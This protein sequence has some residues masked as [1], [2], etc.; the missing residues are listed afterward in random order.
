MQRALDGLDAYTLQVLA[1][2]M[3]GDAGPD[4]HDPAFGDALAD[5]RAL[6]LVWDDGARPRTVP[7]VEDLLRARPPAPAAATRPPLAS[8]ARPP[9][10]LDRAGGTG[11]LEAL[12]LVAALATSW[13]AR[14][15]AQLRSGGVGVRDLHRT[16]REL[17][18][19]E[20]TVALLAETAY[21]AGLLNA[22]HEYEPA[23][24]PTPEYDEWLERPPAVR[25]GVL[26]HAWLTM[27]R[28]PAAVGRRGDRDRVVAMLG[29]DAERGTLP[30]LR[31]RVLAVLA[32]LAPGACP[33]G[34]EQVLAELAWRAPR[35]AA[36]DGPPAAAILAEADLLGIT[37]G[38]GLTGYTR[39][40]LDGSRAVAEQVLADALPAPVS[41]FVVQPDLTLVVPGPPTAALAGDLALIADLESSGGASVYRISAATV[42]RALDAG[43]T[44]ADVHALLTQGSRTPIPQALQ[45]LI[46]DAARRHGT[47]RAGSAGA[48]LRSDDVAL[49]ARVTADRQVAALGLRLLAP[50]VAVS[51]APAARV[52]EVLRAAGFAPAAEGPA[53]DVVAIAVQP[54]RAPSRPAPRTSR[55]RGAAPDGSELAALVRRIRAGDQIS[56]PAGRFDLPAPIPG[57]TSATIMGRL[58]DAIRTEQLVMLGCAEV[59]GTVS[60]HT[61]LPISMGGGYVRGHAPGTERLLSFPLHRLTAVAVLDGPE[62]R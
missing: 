55:S 23:Y 41:E 52:L 34:P 35:R 14:P 1:A 59:D 39:T 25:W 51:P 4:G 13:T 32:E 17:A 20:P 56:A 44:A 29:P 57:V 5:L 60:R 54:P 9:A 10:E 42:R 61:L 3:H 62:D 11:V 2:V 36:L 33:D 21:A 15:P 40:L 24:L 48:Y 43:H 30:A 19:P 53:G 50:T 37:A 45:Y 6:A 7:G 38:G 31:R 18:V 8:S 49:L 58:R 12:R 46:D 16:A 22:T 27:T 26:A 47:L 28:H